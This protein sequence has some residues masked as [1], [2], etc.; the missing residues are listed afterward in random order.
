MSVSRVHHCDK[1]ITMAVEEDRLTPPG[2]K[3]RCRKYISLTKATQ[4]VQNGDATWVVK[5]RTQVL[6][7]VCH[8]C[9]ADPEVKNCAN[10]KGTGKEMVNA[11]VEEYG[12]DIVLVSRPLLDEKK[13]KH[14]AML[15][16]KQMA[17]KKPALKTPRVPTIE[18][19][20]IVR[21]YV[22][23]VKAAQDRIEEYGRLNREFISSLVVGPEPADNP[24]T[25][26]GRC[27]DYGRTI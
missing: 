2:G 23:G 16:S 15:L 11:V 24:K 5:A 18:A 20:H 3:C 17:R 7:D 4:L 19:K 13:K 26:E 10:C 25:G 6:E 27:Y 21:A 1:Q 9:G 8:L 12:E 22:L 14:K